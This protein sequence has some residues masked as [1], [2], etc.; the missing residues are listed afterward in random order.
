MKNTLLQYGGAALLAL[1]IAGCGEDGKDGKDAD[2]AVLNSLQ[3]QIDELVQAANPETCVVCHTGDPSVARTGPKHQEIYKE[4]YQDGIVQV[5]QGSMNLAVTTSGANPND[6]TIF[7][8]RLTKKSPATPTGTPANFDCRLASPTGSIGGYYDPYDAGTGR[9][10][11]VGQTGLMSLKPGASGIAYD[12]GTG[13]C[14][15]T[16]T[17]AVTGADAQYAPL[18]TAIAGGTANGVA[19]V[20]GVD[21]ILETNPAKHMSNGKYPFAGVLKIGTVNYSSAANVAGCENCHTQPFL[22]HAYI[23]GKVTDNAGT[24]TEFYVCKTCHSDQRNGGHQDWQILKDDP[25]RYAQIADGSVP[26]TPAEQAKYSYKTR[27][28]NDV[29]M[30]H[31]MEFAYPQRATNCVTCH[32]GKL[33][34][35]LAPDKFTGETCISC[36]AIE[37][38]DNETSGAARGRGLVP[39]MQANTN[40]HDAFIDPLTNY[41][42][43]K[44]YTTC[45]S[46]HTS[47]TTGPRTFAVL[48]KGGY[49]PLIY[50]T[51]GTRYSTS[52]IT[53][54]TGTSRSGNTLTIDFSATGTVG[55][56]AATSIVPTVMVGLYG[57]DSKDFIVAAH[58]RDASNNRLLE[59]VWGTTNPRFTGTLVAPGQ[60]QVTVDLTM[61]ADKIADGTIKRAEIAVMP[62]LRNAANQIVGLNAPSRTFDLVAN[63]FDDNFMKYDGQFTSTNLVK[64]LK[65]AGADGITGCN[66]CHDQLATTFHSGIRGGNIRVCR[67]CHEVSNAGSH[68]ELQSRSIDSYVHGIHSFQAFD[69]GDIDFTDPVEALHYEHHIGTEF[70]RFGILN[71]ESCHETGRY[72]VPNQARSMPGVLSGTDTVAGRKIGAIPPSVTGPA[73]RACGGCHRAQKI[74]DDDPAELAVLI[75]H[76]KTFGYV[77]DAPTDSTQRATLWASIV[78]K[79]MSVFK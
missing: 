73:V 17:F 65:T 63:A 64:V 44:A 6:R 41:A 19:S 3:A 68:L 22:K 59:W 75:Q 60:W 7:T 23:Y 50:A 27:L 69:P 36:H 35:V 8:F 11:F 38:P 40:V 9:F 31:N 45:A 5:V 30:S 47:T 14:T 71:C 70:P 67:I 61:W 79:I 49:D 1:A 42:T 43:L 77:V 25:A 57:Y 29:H 18:L 76:F 15:W 2:P 21:E 52:I 4:F 78:D 62:E 16:K 12:A 72:N 13:V 34:T 58:G 53:S 33:A 48:H 51:D 39:M 54:I 46:C 66:T 32:E 56:I 37:D 20:Y 10:G 26:I 55:S 24:P 74:N 28:M